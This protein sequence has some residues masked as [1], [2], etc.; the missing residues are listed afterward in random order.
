MDLVYYKRFRMEIDLTGRSI[1]PCRLPDSFFFLPWKDALLD[2]FARA[3]FLSFRNEMDTNVFPCLADFDGCKRLMKAIVDKPGFLPEATWLLVRQTRNQTAPEC[4]G[5]IQG[6]RDPYGIG[7]IQNLG[8][9]RRHRRLGLGSSL[10]LQSLA[11]FSRAG[12]RRVVLEVT[13]DNEQALRLYRRVG[14]CTVKSVYKT[15]ETVRQA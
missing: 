1:P 3:K 11:G 14:F 7:S 13:A 9:V 12:V 10:L 5:T 15:V 4:C 2:A 6:V 8:V